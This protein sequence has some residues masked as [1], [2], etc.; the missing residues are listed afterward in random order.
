[1]HHCWHKFNSS[2]HDDDS[3]NPPKPGS[4]GITALAA[5]TGAAALEDQG[6]V[7]PGRTPCQLFQAVTTAE[8]KP[9]ANA[10][11]GCLW[12]H[13]QWVMHEAGW[14]LLSHTQGSW[15]TLQ[16]CHSGAEVGNPAAKCWA[17]SAPTSH[18]VQESTQA[19]ARRTFPSPAKCF[20]W[21]LWLNSEKLVRAE[22]HA[23]PGGS[24]QQVAEGT[25]LCSLW[26]P[27]EQAGR[28]Q[29]NACAA[30]P[31]EARS[32]GGYL[33]LGTSS[34][35]LHRGHITVH[36]GGCPSIRRGSVAKPGIQ[37]HLA[38]LPRTPSV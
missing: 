15:R 11:H 16:L 32:I 28:G 12:L 5:A 8:R 3:R 2:T 27:E 20:P 17:F 24:P 35:C 23:L 26:H 18:W 22:G 29:T 10:A 21:L 36:N 14:S 37:P 6:C 4:S 38:K 9:L 13:L 31:K 25:G 7:S 19:E 34:G 1:M 33:H 30:E